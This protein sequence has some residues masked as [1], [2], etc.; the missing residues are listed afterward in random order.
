MD[1]IVWMIIEL[2]NTFLET[3]ITYLYFKDFLG[4][5]LSSKKAINIIS[6]TS[7][8]IISGMVYLLVPDV[9]LTAILSL[10]T[11]FMYSL[12]FKGS[13]KERSFASIILVALMLVSEMLTLFTISL[14]LRATIQTAVHDG[15]YRFAGIVISIIISFILSRIL[16]IAKQY[17]KL[18]IPAWHWVILL[19]TPFL[20]IL[21]IYTLFMYNN[22]VNNTQLR[23]YT[24]FT[25]LSIIYINF[26]IFYLFNKITTDFNLKAQNKLLEQ[27]ITYQI[28]HYRDLEITNREISGLRHDMRNHLQCLNGLLMTNRYVEAKDYINSVTNVLTVN[29]NVISTGNSV[30]DSL[31]NAKVMMINEKQIKFT[32]TILIG[33]S[34][35]VA[36]MDICVL[37]GNSLDNAIEA[38]ER[39]KSREPYIEL[40]IGYSNGNLTL[41]LTNPVDEKPVEK[42]GYYLSAKRGLKEHGFGLSNIQRTIEKYDGAFEIT[43]KDHMFKLTAMLC[44]V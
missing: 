32:Y 16:C 44:N 23:I 27:Q 10:L 35:R 26:I 43:V 15:P 29:S 14:L 8:F 4:K 21:V 24:Y 1:K 3:L 17:K 6:F 7:V 25:S 18:V 13:L 40:A 5:G 33:Q 20:S 36:P 19:T 11:R 38:C 31:L 2:A 41:S 34:L 30:L 9:L 22:I 12:V 28:A 42:G 37:F 39:V